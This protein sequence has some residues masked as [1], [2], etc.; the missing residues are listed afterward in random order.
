[1]LSFF[2]I[3]LEVM[4]PEEKQFVADS[5]KFF[6]HETLFFKFAN[7][8]GTRIEEGIQK[9]PEKYRDRVLTGADRALRQCLKAAIS[10]T[11]QGVKNNSLTEAAARSNAI[12]LQHSAV[13]AV[14]GGLSGLGGMLLLIPELPVTTA[15]MMRS[16]VETAGEFGFDVNEPEVF[17]ECLF[18]FSMG[19]PQESDNA[20][21]T[22]YF[23]N[24]IFMRTFMR[25]AMEGM[26]GQGTKQFLNLFE[27]SMGPAFSRF[28]AKV[29][30]R[31]GI[32]VSEKFAV[33]ILPVVSAL[34]G[35]A[36]NVAFNQYFSTAAKYHFGLK[37]LERDHGEETVQTIYRLEAAKSK[38]QTLKSNE[39]TD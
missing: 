15:V 37:K 14:T 34:S 5:A 10:S 19:G 20:A 32:R 8:L 29:G 13:S 31:F 6:E 17:M 24:R 16:I 12:T 11:K 3:M 28:M 27:K 2:L 9:L 35:A 4:T 18:V 23:S 25:Q 39:R 1:M 21:D 36:I 26:G 22:A 33:Q 30:E 38:V 7:V